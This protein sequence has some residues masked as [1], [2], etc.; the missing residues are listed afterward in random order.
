MSEKNSSQTVKAKALGD[1]IITEVCPQCGQ[2]HKWIWP[3]HPQ[4]GGESTRKCCGKK[5]E[6]KIVP[7]SDYQEP[8]DNIEEKAIEELVERAKDGDREAKK[9]LR[10]LSRK[11]ETE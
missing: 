11:K 2:I 10:S 5:I 4:T 9:A 8:E 7:E 6:V 3:N 1:M